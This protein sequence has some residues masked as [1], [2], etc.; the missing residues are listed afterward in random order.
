[1]K[2]ILYTLTCPSRFHSHYQG[3]DKNPKY[4]GSSPLDAQSYLTK[5]FARVR[6]ALAR[7]GIECYGM[8]IVEPHHDGTPHWHLLLFMDSSLSAAATAIFKQYA[9]EDSGDEPGAL[10]RRFTAL[11]MDPAKGSA[12]GYLAKYIS[13]NIDG[14]H[15]GTDHYG[16]DAIQS[17]IRIEAW[18]S[19]WGIRQFQQIGGASITVYRETRRLEADGLDPGLLKKIVQAAD[20]GNWAEYCTLMGGMTCPRNERPLRPYMIP[21]KK[22]NRF[23]EMV[24]VLKGIWFGPTYVLT[25]V[26]EWIVRPVRQ[27]I[28][29][30][31]SGEDGVRH[32]AA[33]S[34]APPGACVPLDLCQ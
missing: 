25:R 28:E 6:S 20:N 9:L 33:E 22:L 30:A 21:R 24:K 8:R 5:L 13:K 27:V 29:N 17:A 1:M 32:G 19:T 14:S 2:G 3:G 34:N 26:H 10:Q 16:R 23:G 11:E 4:D 7:A 31:N 12:A 18:A 15:V